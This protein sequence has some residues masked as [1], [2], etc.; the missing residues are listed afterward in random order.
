MLTFVTGNPSK[1]EQLGLH[2]HIEVTHKKLEL[3]EIQSLS[4]EEIVK[5]KVM[6]AYKHV[7]GPVLVEDTSLIFYAL[8]RLP[9]PLIKW[10]LQELDSEGLCN[11]LSGFQSR[12]AI[13]EVLF[14]YYD[15]S[16]F[17]TF[18]GE[19]EGTIAEYPRGE[20]GFGWDPIFIP[21]GYSK[22]WGEMTLE[23]QIATSM[24]RQALKKLEEFLMINKESPM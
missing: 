2:L 13:A 20:R 12:K 10:F 17:T 3:D 11:M 7:Q 6:E 8:G 4:L 16:L 14:G 24:R 15:G 19:I 18:K 5:H 23:H 22:T 21:E 1:A 9:G